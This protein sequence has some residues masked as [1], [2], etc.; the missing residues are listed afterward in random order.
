MKDIPTAKTILRPKLSV[1]IKDK[2][3]KS[4]MAIWQTVGSWFR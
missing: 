2:F 3:C 1:V 4:L